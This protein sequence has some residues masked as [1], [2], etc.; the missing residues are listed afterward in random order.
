MNTS[1][2]KEFGNTVNL[3]RLAL[4]S[5]KFE[6]YVNALASTK[7]VC[8]RRK[9]LK[10]ITENL[11]LLIGLR[12]TIDSAHAKLNATA[13]LCGTN[14]LEEEY[15]TEV[16]EYLNSLSTTVIENAPLYA[17]MVESVYQKLDSLIS[18]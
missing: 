2:V 5:E 6:Y 3:L 16:Q 10:A 12:I 8:T 7:D 13:M 4:P 18:K 14:T 11:N 9:E 1:D 17:N 15:K